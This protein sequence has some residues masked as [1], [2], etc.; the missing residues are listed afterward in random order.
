[1][2]SGQ[3]TFFLEIPDLDLVTMGCVLVIESSEETDN[4]GG[5]E[6]VGAWTYGIGAENSTWAEDS[7]GIEDS[8][9][10][11]ELV[12]TENPDETKELDGM[13]DLVE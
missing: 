3:K 6:D 1:M 7:A 2:F 8:P 11:L 4:S 9:R 5:T 12:G 13:E 10:G